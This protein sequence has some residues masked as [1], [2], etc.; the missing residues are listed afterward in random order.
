MSGRPTP[1]GSVSASRLSEFLHAT[2]H[3]VGG[4]NGQIHRIA[5]L[6][7]GQCGNL[8]Q[9]AQSWLAHLATAT[10]HL[11][12]RLEGVRRYTEI[13]DLPR[14]VSRFS[15]G[16]ALSA[17]RLTISGD[18]TITAGD[19]PEVDADARRL[20]LVFKELLSNACKFHAGELPEVRVSVE[21]DGGWLIVS[22]DDNGIGIEP[23]QA[24]RIFMPFVQLWGDRFPGTG[25][26]LTIAR[27]LVEGW[28]GRIWAASTRGAGSTFRFTL[29]L[30]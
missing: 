22:L 28:G 17:A 15:M 30:S 11:D 14:T 10:G 16:D 13:F 20:Q 1:D 18:C 4:A 12:E 9:G 2:L 21:N 6:L 25:I 27:E 8:D 23:H 24:E 7:Q 19:L 3:A 5:G 26:G 29:P